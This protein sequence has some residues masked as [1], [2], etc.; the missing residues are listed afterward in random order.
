MM[1]SHNVACSCRLFSDGASRGNPGPAGAGWVI[2]DD[3]G[4]ELAAK[5]M[6][7]GHCTNNVAEYRALL[8]GLREASSLGCRRLEVR[9]DSE[10]IVRQLQGRY[11][12]KHPKLKPL[13]AE[14]KVLLANFA[15]WNAEHVPRE[16]NRRADALANQGIDNGR[17][18]LLTR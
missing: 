18:E 4:R 1:A 17:K 14:A 9:L 3:Q 16:Q 5:G 15:T 10:L 11:Q 2:L 7:L 13:F 6:F 8:A 12:V